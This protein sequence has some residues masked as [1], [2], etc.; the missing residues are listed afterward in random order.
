MITP[1]EIEL[2]EFSRSMRGYDRD[3]VDEFLDVI[4]LD[5]QDLLKNMEIIQAENQQLREEIEEHKQSEKKVM[6]TLESA[7]RLMKDMSDSAEKRADIIIQNAKIDAE[8]ILNDARRSVAGQPITSGGELHDKVESFRLR[9]KQLLQDELD[10]LEGRSVDLLSELEKEFIPASLD[11]QII[12]FDEMNLQ[13]TDDLIAKLESEAEELAK[14]T[15]IPAP[16]DTV[17]LDADAID[18]ILAKKEEE[19]KL[20]KGE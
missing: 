8:Q 13:E 2:K 5:L 16:K 3:E 15:N 7:K 6:E 19:L 14:K 10:S 9:Y 12:D 4:I 20:T 18:E 1:Q 17:V 11:T